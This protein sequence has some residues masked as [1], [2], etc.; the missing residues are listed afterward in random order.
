MYHKLRT[1]KRWLDEGKMSMDDIKTSFVSFQGHLKHCN[2]YKVLQKIK[3]HFNK[4][5]ERYLL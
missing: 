4:L 5:F 3:R 2:A 1:F